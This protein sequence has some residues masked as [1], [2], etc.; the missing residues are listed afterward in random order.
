M[1]MTSRLRA[2]FWA[3]ILNCLVARYGMM[4]CFVLGVVNSTDKQS[5]G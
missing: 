4:C 1:L 5:D 2:G 3:A